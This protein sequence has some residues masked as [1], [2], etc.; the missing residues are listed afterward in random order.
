MT[1]FEKAIRVRE[2]LAADFLR[3][4]TGRRGHFRLESGHHSQLWIDLDALFADP[5]T[6]DPFVE[7]RRNVP[8]TFRN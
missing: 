4:V 5:S 6:V 1:P 2:N 7:V 3:I 8:A